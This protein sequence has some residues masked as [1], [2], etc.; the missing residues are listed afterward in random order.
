MGGSTTGLIHP[1]ELRRLTISEI[2]AAVVDPGRVRA[3]GELRGA[4]G[5]DRQFRAPVA[6][7]RDR[8]ERPGARP[9]RRGRAAEILA[10]TGRDKWLIVAASIR[11]GIRRIGIGKSFVHVDNDASLPNPTI[12][13][14]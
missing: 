13:L 2:K 12:W 4:V 1:R 3:Q 6:H 7:V 9:R 14:Y 5:Q 10:L 8:A 11:N